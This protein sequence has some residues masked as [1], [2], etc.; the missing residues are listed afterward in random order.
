MRN[1]FSKL[2]SNPIS[3]SLLLRRTGSAG[4]GVG[5]GGHSSDPGTN[6][7]LQSFPAWQGGRQEWE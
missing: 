4:G 2:G 1:Q 5:V 7:F 6:P 3:Q